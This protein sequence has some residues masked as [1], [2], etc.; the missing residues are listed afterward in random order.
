MLYDLCMY[1]FIYGFLGWVIEVAFHAAS[2]HKLVNRGFLNGAICP[3]YG[4]GMVIMIVLLEP[5][6]NNILLL[7]VGSFILCS[8]LEFITGFVLERIFHHRWWDYSDEKFNIR[9]YI[10][11]RFS[12]CW[13]AAGV[14]AIKVIHQSISDLVGW[15]PDAVQKMITGVLVLLLVIDIAATVINVRGLN[16]DLTHIDEMGDAIRKVSDELTKI[17]YDESLSV[18]DKY[19]ESKTEINERRKE[20]EAIKEALQDKKDGAVRSMSVVQKRLIKTFPKGHSLKHRETMEQIK[21][22]IL[23]TDE[24]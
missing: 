23:K 22:K 9:G 1:F 8:V 3:I 10:C 15:M 5:L 16:K 17:I 4:V 2:Q 14:V 24:K 12:L 19:E 20:L 11:L 6:K 18:K 13:G 7:F 21:H